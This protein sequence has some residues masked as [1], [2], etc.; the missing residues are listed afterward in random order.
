MRAPMPQSTDDALLGALKERF[1][2]HVERHPG[3][4]WRDAEARLR[5]EPSK[6]AVVREMERTGGEPD[7]VGRPTRDGRLTFIDCAPESPPGRRSLCNDRVALDSRKA[8]KPLGSAI[9][10]AAAMGSEPLTEAQ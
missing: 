7:V 10:V 8:N 5:D 3:I 1:E 6:L 4:D 9:G 2:R